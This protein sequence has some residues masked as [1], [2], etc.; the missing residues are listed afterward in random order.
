MRRGRRVRPTSG[1]AVYLFVALAVLYAAACQNNGAAYILTFFL[2]ALLGVGVMQGL[3]NTA[4]LEARQV[5][6]A[7]GMAPA[8][9][10][11]GSGRVE[12]RLALT[13]TGRIRARALSLRL[14][15]QPGEPTLLPAL[16]PGE[17]RE[18]VV[19]LHGLA[20]G[21]YALEGAEL[22]TEY[23]FG[24][25]RVARTLPLERPEG[26]WIYPAPRPGGERPEGPSDHAGTGGGGGGG[27]DFAGVRPYRE[28]ESQR[29]VDW[30]AVARGNPRMVKQFAGGVDRALVL[31]WDFLSTPPEAR[32]RSLCYWLFEAEQQG[33]RYGLRLP[34]GDFPPGGGQEH[35]HTLLRALA[36]FPGGAERGPA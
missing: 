19:R 4:L 28:G 5:G 3:Q 23:P 24:L 11:P 25:T 14:V 1:L 31:D 22:T 33:A 26:V 7:Y 10:V 16:P 27:E 32:L 17:T 20:R 34:G 15:G 36:S 18:I 29:H 6:T 21:H 8:A 9:D 13:N 2:F 30:K 35:L 12:V